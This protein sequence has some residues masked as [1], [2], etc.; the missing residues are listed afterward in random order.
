MEDTF[1]GLLNVARDLKNSRKGED[2]DNNNVPP[3]E[4]TQ[5]SCAICNEQKPDGYQPLCCQ[6][7]VCADCIA[8]YG[9]SVAPFFLPGPDKAPICPW[10]EKKIASTDAM[11][12][13]LSADK[14]PNLAGT[15]GGNAGTDAEAW[16][17]KLYHSCGEAFVV[18]GWDECDV[19]AGG[20]P[21][22]GARSVNLT[23]AEGEHSYQLRDL[24]SALS[25]FHARATARS[26]T[27]LRD[28]FP[29]AWRALRLTALVNTIA[30][31]VIPDLSLWS[32][33]T[34]EFL[35]AR[36]QAIQKELD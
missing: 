22:C 7:F 8:Q 10:C 27:K 20:C 30:A 1:T 29:D 12:R 19:L 3:T 18:I 33:E 26:F 14:L 21:A 11:S 35:K 28:D 9:G 32:K 5:R 23:G 25:K 13:W 24:L 15:D 4:T 2:E 16:N 31:G 17:F 36:A 6:N 34:V